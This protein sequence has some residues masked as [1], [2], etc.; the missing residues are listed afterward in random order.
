[1]AG[2]QPG[3][4]FL[5]ITPD[6][7]APEGEAGC[8]VAMVMPHGPAATAGVIDG[9]LIVQWAGKP[10]ANA[11]D[12][13]SVIRGCKPGQ[14]VTLTVRRAGETLTLDVTLGTR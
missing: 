3:G 8:A 12:L 11:F 2:V 5:G 4:A 9:D 10:I 13:V 1:M 6:L 7:G 14:T